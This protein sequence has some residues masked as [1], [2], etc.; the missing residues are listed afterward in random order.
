MSADNWTQC[1]ACV[2]KALKEYAA[3]KRKLDADY[4]KVPA[5]AFVARRD[6]LKDPP[7]IEDTLREDYELGVCLN[8]EFYVSYSC[9][10][11]ACNFAHTHEHSEQLTVDVPG[12]E[13]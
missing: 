12:E 3:A 13:N 9:L 11:S 2:A 4:G 6:A 7:K 8:G 5:E 10:C 1:P